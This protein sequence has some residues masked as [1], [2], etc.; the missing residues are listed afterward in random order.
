MAQNRSAATN[1]P[2]EDSLAPE[3]SLNLVQVSNVKVMHAAYTQ[4]KPEHELNAIHTP[5]M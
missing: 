2:Q 3:I 5:S 1:S 4:K